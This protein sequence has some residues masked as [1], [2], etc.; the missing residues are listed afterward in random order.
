MIADYYFIRKQELSV[1]DLYNNRGIYVFKNGYNNV[2]ITAL[3]AGIL[4]N[5][6]GFL[7]QI[8]LVS[9][10]F[11]PGWLSGLYHYAW[12]VGFIISAI[13][14]KLMMGTKTSLIP[15]MSKTAL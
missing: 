15:V 1:P 5:V 8:K 12:F 7:L 6:P 3:L 4:P 11:F 14:Y 2:A 10:H 13:V 9:S